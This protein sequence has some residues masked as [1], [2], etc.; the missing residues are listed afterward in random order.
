MVALNIEQKNLG[1][2][3]LPQPE[4]KYRQCDSLPCATGF[5]GSQHKISKTELLA[6]KFDQSLIT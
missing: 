4:A 1:K 6:H 5:F 3:D 2:E